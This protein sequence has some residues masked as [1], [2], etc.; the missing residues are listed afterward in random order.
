MSHA[1]APSFLAGTSDQYAIAAAGADGPVAVSIGHVHSRGETR[2]PL[3]LG[4]LDPHG[5]TASH[6]NR[7]FTDYPSRIRSSDADSASSSP[8]GLQT[9]IPVT[10]EATR[11]PNPGYIGSFSHSGILA[12]IS[13]SHV[14]ANVETAQAEPHEHLS[15]TSNDA[16]LEDRD[17]LDRAADCIELLHQLNFS[18]LSRLVTSWLEKGVNL[19]LA[20]PFIAACNDAASTL[21]PSNETQTAHP[22]QARAL[23]LNSRRPISLS[24][25]SC[26]SEFIAQITGDF[27]RWETIGLF[28]AAASRAVLDTPSFSPIYLNEDQRMPF[29]RT[30]TKICNFC[31]E[32]ALALDCLNDLQFVLQFENFMIHTHVN[33]DQS[34]PIVTTRY[35]ST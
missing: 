26:L 10:T 21:G 6:P 11:Y 4:N 13:S 12:E 32:I 31:L 1:A 22:L 29:I 14:A 25:D 2:E 5:Q 30:L 34:K 9:S 28:L 17:I 16:L 27:L 15:S 19:N 18:D 33:G 20:E 8:A 24:R 23:L 35:C 7:I 3:S